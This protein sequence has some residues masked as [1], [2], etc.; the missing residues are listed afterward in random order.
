MHVA[1]IRDIELLT[2]LSFLT[3]WTHVESLTNVHTEAIR[4]KLHIEE[5]TD[6][7][8]TDFLNSDVPFD[9]QM[10]DITVDQC[11]VY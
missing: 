2:G 8:L 10:S 7:W 9:L 1:R 4:A 11:N 3:K 5:F 6:Q